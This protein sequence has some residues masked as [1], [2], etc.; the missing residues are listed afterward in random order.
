MTD[1][2]NEPVPSSEPAEDYP[3]PASGEPGSDDYAGDTA[4]EVVGPEDAEG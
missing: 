3:E 4:D 2:S 1:Q